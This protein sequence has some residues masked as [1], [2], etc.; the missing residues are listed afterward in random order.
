MLDATKGFLISGKLE[1]FFDLGGE[2]PSFL[3][4]EVSAS[5][6][7]ALNEKITAAFRIKTGSIFGPDASKIPATKRFYAG[8]GG[9]VRGFGYQRVGP[10]KDDEPEGG[11]SLIE[12][13]TE[14]RFKITGKIGAVAFIDT[15]NVYN[16]SL[17]DFDNLYV[18]GGGGLRYYTKAG[19]LRLDIAVPIN[20]K[21]TTPDNYQLYMSIGQAF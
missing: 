12:A 18:G 16:T 1:P 11:L 20:K 13:S 17:A 8:G 15:G 19:P 9:S 14:L 10:L 3:K 5:A 2:S 4:T 21:E 7:H 6:Y